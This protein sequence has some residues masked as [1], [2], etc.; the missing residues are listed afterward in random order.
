ML[1]IPDITFNI[2]KAG[3]W[4]IVCSKDI[5]IP[6]E[7]I[8]LIGVSG[9]FINSDIVKFYDTPQQAQKFNKTVCISVNDS[10]VMNAWGADLDIKFI[11]LI[12]DG[13][14]A[15]T[16]A[17]GKLQYTVYGLRSKNYL[18]VIKD[19]QINYLYEEY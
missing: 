1:S 4:H 13:N 11:D 3:E 19:N 12:P 9:A 8:F 16:T 6:N 2:R 15:F 14:A 18:A 17:L 10:F 5:F 7:T